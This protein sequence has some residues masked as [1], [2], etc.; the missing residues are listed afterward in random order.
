MTTL[1]LKKDHTLEAAFGL[2]KQ[3]N[4]ILFSITMLKNQKVSREVMQN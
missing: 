3:P 2:H 1:R 4:T